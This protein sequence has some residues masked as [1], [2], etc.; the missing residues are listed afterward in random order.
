VTAHTETRHGI[1][2]GSVG[3]PYVLEGCV[4]TM[5][6]AFQVIERGR[7]Y[8]RAGDIVAV[9]EREC[10]APAGL[11]NAPLIKTR[12]TIF[13]GLIELHN[14]LSYNV[15]PMWQVPHTFVHRGQWADHPDKRRLISQPMA[16]LASIG[17]MIQ[18]IVRYVEAKCLV[19]GVTTSQGMCL[20]AAPGISHSYRGIVRNVEQT[21]DAALPEALTRIPDV[22]N[23]EE[24]LARLER[25]R[26][27]AFLLHLA[28]GVGPVARKHF[29]ALQIAGARW[30]ITRSLVGIHGTGLQDGDFDVFAR[31]GAGLVWSPLSNLL[32]YGNTLDI[33]RA[34]QAGLRLALGSDWSPSGSKNL[35][36]ELK[37]ALAWSEQ[38]GGVF[39]PR[40][41]VTMATIEPARMIGWD[42]ALGSICAGKQADLVVIAG[43]AHDAYER[44]LSARDNDVQLVLIRGEPRFGAARL[45]KQMQPVVE[46]AAAFESRGIGGKPF[47]FNFHQA[48]ADPLVA[49]VTLAEAESRLREGLRDLPKL[50]SGLADRKAHPSALG[51]VGAAQ[52]DKPARRWTLALDNEM[53]D[54]GEALGGTT[55]PLV[56]RSP[57]AGALVGSKA[58]PHDIAAV[59]LV[60]LPLDALTVVDDDRYF[61]R[62]T[63]APG[64]PKELKAELPRLQRARV[65]R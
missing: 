50:A 35:L 2:D 57:Q 9:Q 19:G 53:H 8:I 56:P 52:A 42:A 55:R 60:S 23:A 20:M 33:R 37:V 26:G 17:S 48:S 38:H 15:L 21:D 5:N 40:E 34:K 43:R 44:L 65:R 24:F 46:G 16:V 30:A 4:V 18:A 54:S 10:A 11:E 49:P 47:L 7:V 14:H 36:S 13:P 59:K 58:G 25:A 29:L 22:E 41:L 6:D 39:T 31:M 12:G 64:L 51:I 3:E 1:I 62:L 27:R 63:Q 28:E 45:M 32:L 61:D